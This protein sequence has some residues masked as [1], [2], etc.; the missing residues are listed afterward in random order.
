VDKNTEYEEWTQL[1]YQFRNYLMSREDIIHSENSLCS[2]LIY[3]EHNE[4]AKYQMSM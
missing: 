3:T 2:T 1:Y 4:P